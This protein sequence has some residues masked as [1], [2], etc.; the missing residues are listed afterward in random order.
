MLTVMTSSLH[1]IKL[2]ACSIPQSELVEHALPYI[3]PIHCLSKWRCIYVSMLKY[4]ELNCLP[5][6]VTCTP[7]IASKI[8]KHF[9]G[10]IPH[11]PLLIGVAYVST[12]YEPDHSKPDGYGLE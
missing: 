7:S 1:T 6:D 12:H 4:A 11:G 8:P 10:S 2:N 5:G 9:W 3:F